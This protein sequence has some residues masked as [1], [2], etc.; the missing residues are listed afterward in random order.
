MGKMGFSDKWV[1]LIMECVYT[2][3]YSIIVNGQAVGCIKPSR[4][5]RQ[6]DPLSPY[7][8]LLCAEALNS[9]LSKAEQIGVIIGVPTSKK[10]P[11]LS[12]LFFADNNLLF[13]KAN[14]VEWRRLTKLLEA[15][16]QVSGQKL[17]REKKS[18]FFSRNTSPEK[19]EITRLSD[20]KS[21]V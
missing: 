7:L 18:I 10:G 16:K 2:V 17:N 4:R 21:V 11:R 12:H 13:C 5:I 14:S 20:R 6:G 15:Y 19:E 9:M 1:K 8:F 3:T